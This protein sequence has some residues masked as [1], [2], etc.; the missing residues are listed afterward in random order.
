MDYTLNEFPD[1][2]RE[3]HEK[4]AEKPPE[5]KEVK[6]KKKSYAQILDDPE[7]ESPDMDLGQKMS[8]LYGIPL[9][10]MDFTKVGNQIVKD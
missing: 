7:N 1:P 3:I 2:F 9:D 10:M 6:V 5:K 8:E 4:K